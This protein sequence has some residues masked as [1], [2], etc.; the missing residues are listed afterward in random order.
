M[1]MIQDCAVVDLLICKEPANMNIFFPMNLKPGAVRH[2]DH[3]YGI[4]NADAFSVFHDV[5]IS[6]R[7]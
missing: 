3:P 4:L 5:N 2:F 6:F 1:I 7:R